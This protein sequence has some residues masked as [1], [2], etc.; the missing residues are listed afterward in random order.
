M[1]FLF[2]SIMSIIFLLIFFGAIADLHGQYLIRGVVIDQSDTTYIPYASVGLSGANKGT[3]GNSSGRFELNLSSNN[4]GDTLWISA[5]GYNDAF[6]I[7]EPEMKIHRIM[8]EPRSY[9]LEGLELKAS[10]KTKKYL[11]GRKINTRMITGG[12]SSTGPGAEIATRISLK[13]KP[14]WLHSVGFHL[15]SCKLDRIRFRLNI[16]EI[17][18]DGNPGRN[19][20]RKN[21]F[22]TPDCEPGIYEFEIKEYQIYLDQDVYVGLEW[23]EDYSD[24]GDLTFASYISKKESFFRSVAFNSWQKNTVYS[25]SIWIRTIH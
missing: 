9:T 15:G 23:F 19:I 14:A 21:I 7:I 11:E 13:K 12:F 5:L 6:V 18:A 10:K 25:T 22:L 17:G 3:V 20:L 8:L 1:E 2:R 24:S 4:I 16:Y